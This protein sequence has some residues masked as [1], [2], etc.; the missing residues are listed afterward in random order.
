MILPVYIVDAFTDTPFRGNPAA[1]VPLESWLPDNRLQ[2]IAAQ[3]NLSETAFT[4][5]VSE[6]YDLR[7]FT[8]RVEVDLCGHATLAAAHVHC[9]ER[10]H[11]G[12][13][14]HFHTKSGLLEVARHRDCRYTL[15]FPCDMPTPVFDFP[16]LLG[17]ALGTI[18][19]SVW[20]GRFDYLVRLE[21]EAEVQRLTPKMPLLA[22]LEARGIIVTAWSSPDGYVSRFFAPA[23]GVD[24]DPVTGSAHCTLTSFWAEMKGITHFQAR[25]L[26]AR[27]GSLECTLAGERVLLT[28]DARLYLQGQIHL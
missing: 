15:D 27:G 13:R 11:H 7:W 23:C 8:P 22:G 6:G 16:S 19:T 14:I 21:T 5:P 4:V 1:V 12:K 24:E 25:Q 20:K 3:H 9:S 17:E 26:S 18:P 2:A 28:G 10:G